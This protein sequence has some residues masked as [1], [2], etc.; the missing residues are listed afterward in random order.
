L[1]L[2]DSIGSIINQTYQNWECI[3]IDD[4][5]T[6]NSKEIIQEFCDKDSRINYF[7][8]VNSGPTVARNY[9]VRLAKGELIQ[10]LDADDLLEKSKLEMH[11]AAFNRDPDCDIVYGS[12]KYFTT[13]NPSKFYDSLDLKSGPW[14]KNISGSGDVMIMELLRGNIMETSSPLVRKLLFDRLGTMN[15]ELFFNEDWELWARFALGN[16]KFCFNDSIGTLV[17]RRAHESYS[18][19]VFKMWSSGLKVS[20]L[21]NEKVKDYKYKKILIPKINYH[22]RIIDEELLEMLLVDK[23]KAADYALQVYTQTG[24]KRYLRYSKL[25]NVAPYWFCYLYSK[26]VFLINKVKNIIIYS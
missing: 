2:P 3:I 4:G 25:F 22:K 6:D 7:L 1:F 15:E 18:K 16:A 14:M 12:V 11:V 26:F 9:G 10:F 17:L 20:L 24:V 8:Q 21:L 23:K 13:S 19:A 5:S